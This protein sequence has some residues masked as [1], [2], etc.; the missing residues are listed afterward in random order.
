[1]STQKEENDSF[2]MLSAKN[3]WAIRKKIQSSI[4]STVTPNFIQSLLGFKDE[5][6]A[7]SNVLAPMRKLGLIDDGGKPTDLLRLWRNDDSYVQACTEM[8]NKV[9]PDELLTLIS[10]D[11]LDK[12]A[13]TRWFMGKD[14]GQAAAGKMVAL[15]AILKQ[16]DPTPPKTINNQ[17]ASKQP[18]S[19]R[20]NNVKLKEKDNN[21]QP[22]TNMPLNSAIAPSVHIDLQL[23]FSPDL[24]PEQINAIFESMSKYLYRA[25]Q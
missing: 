4:P 24:T 1:M 8:L 19:A 18:S 11:P 2:P 20:A 22:V 21:I 14:A 5:A 15:L 6:S 13:A 7:R 12:Q 10:G 9:Y 3:W 16:A 17:K 25:Q 23:H